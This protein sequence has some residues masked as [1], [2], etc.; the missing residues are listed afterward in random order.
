VLLLS[1]FAREKLVA[2]RSDAKRHS[3]PDEGDLCEQKNYR[4]IALMTCLKN[5]AHVARAVQ[6]IS[7]STPARIYAAKGGQTITRGR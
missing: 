7:E 6:P 5:A 3:L 1:V 4:T 2:A